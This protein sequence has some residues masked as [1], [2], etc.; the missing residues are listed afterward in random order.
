[1]LLVGNNIPIL[2]RFTQHETV[3]ISQDLAEIVQFFCDFFPILMQGRKG[4]LSNFKAEW[5]H[6]KL[7]YDLCIIAIVFSIKSLVESYLLSIAGPL[8]TWLL[9]L[10]TEVRK[11]SN[12]AVRFPCKERLEIP[13]TIQKASIIRDR[14]EKTTASPPSV[15]NLS[16]ESCV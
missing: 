12:S 14:E 11:S 1:M 8:T 10:A 5:N 9:L 2:H 4:I 13:Y 15:I 6:V 3:E 7:I 16:E